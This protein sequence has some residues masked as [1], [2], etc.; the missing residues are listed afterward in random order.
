LARLHWWCQLRVGITVFFLPVI[1]VFSGALHAQYLAYSFR[2]NPSHGQQ[3]YQTACVSCHGAGG[4]GAPQTQ[5]VFK[6][7]DT[8][9]DFTRC[10]QTT[11]ETNTAY[12]DVITHGG[13]S[14]GFSTIMP[15]FGEALSSRDIDDIVAYLREFCPD[16]HWARGE[17]NLPRALVTEKA[18]PESELVLT[19]AINASGTPGN[20][21]HIIHEQ[22]FGMKNQ[23][24]VDLPIT[25]EDQNH[26]WYG[27][28]GDITL[29]FKREMY[30]N[31]RKGSIFSLF[32]GFLVPSG[33]HSRGFGNGTTTFETFAAYDQLFRSDTWVQLQFGAE[34]PFD[35]SKAPQ[36]IFFNSAIG[37]TFAPNSKLGRMWSPMV[38]FTATRD[39]LDNANTDWNVIPEMQVTISKRQHVRGNLGL[40]VPMTNTDGRQ[41]QLLFYLL[42]D[43]A[44]GKLWEGW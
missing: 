25:F 39:L 18:F 32:G 2:A 16:Q 8:F 19:T 28:V 10:D 26:V 11:P 38:E 9:P 30:S 34:L 35:T 33:N 14:R 17:L 3:I 36:S 4:A 29:G 22:R 43:W 27:G 1:L 6:R 44:D 31:L 20:Q 5:S 37:Q 24:E 40:S 13:P 7:P 21:T 12:K 42:W 41:K 15:A 23:I